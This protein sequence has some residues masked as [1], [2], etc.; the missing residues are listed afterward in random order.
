M[1]AY[2]LF[3]NNKDSSIEPTKSTL[4]IKKAYVTFEDSQFSVGF[5]K[6][7]LTEYGG[8]T[9]Q[10]YVQLQ[11]ALAM[12]LNS[13]AKLKGIG[14][15]GHK[16]KPYVV[17]YGILSKKALTL[18][19]GKNENIFKAT[20]D[21]QT[22]SM[23]VLDTHKRIPFNGD[24]RNKLNAFI[25]DVPLYQAYIKE[26]II[27]E[28]DTLNVKALEA[29]SLGFIGLAKKTEAFVRVAE[30]TS[31]KLAFKVY[32]IPGKEDPSYKILTNPART[33]KTD[34]FGGIYY[35]YPSETTQTAQFFSYDDPSFTLNG[36]KKEA[37]YKQLQIG[38]TSFSK[39]NLTGEYKERIGPLSMY[40]FDLS[41]PSFKVKKRSAGFYAYLNGAYD[42]LLK[43][44]VQQQEKA[45]LKVICLKESNSQKE[46]LVDTNLTFKRL[47]RILGHNRENVP[48]L[49][50]EKVFIT[51]LGKTT[52]WSDYLWAIRSFI[53]EWKA[54]PKILIKKYSKKLLASRFDIL[55]HREIDGKPGGVWAKEY[56][57][58]A[59]IAFELLT[60]GK[61]DESMTSD[62]Q[63][64]YNVGKIAAGYINFKKKAGETSNSLT[65]L[66]SYTKYDESKLR[67][68]Y[69]QV[70]R[71]V[72]LSNA[73]DKQKKEITNFIKDNTPKTLKLKNPSTDLS[74]FFFRGVFNVLKE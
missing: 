12:P 19:F 1:L 53:Y 32:I 72:Q 27:N 35:K 63:F 20:L 54:N 40:L 15:T 30:E 22:G 70:S 37:F 46:V 39:I 48:P 28:D 47:E 24:K 17:L 6:K 4:P 5:D 3:L 43:Q 10:R 49:L 31:G 18:Y 29:V 13:R 11:K 41:D 62:E 50:F 65:G 59:D 36:A 73:N 57:R 44:H 51:R 26:H 14:V 34:A 69:E 61:M 67:F 66:L 52:L 38:D 56:L 45:S 2:E 55:A 64:A 42:Q 74:Y 8:S 23:D 60:G 71:G 58:Y 33:T 68:V 7:T 21:L 16:P 9:T 25:G